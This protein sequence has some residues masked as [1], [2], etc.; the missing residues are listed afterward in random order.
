MKGPDW[1]LVAVFL[2][3]ILCNLRHASQILKPRWTEEQATSWYE[4]QPWLVGANYV[5]SDAINE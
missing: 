3:V 5:P 2:V 1:K 4:G